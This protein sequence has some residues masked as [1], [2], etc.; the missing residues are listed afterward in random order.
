M[1]PSS[2]SNSGNQPPPPY[3]MRYRNQLRDKLA[4][5]KEYIDERRG[6]DP[7]DTTGWR[8]LLQ[9]FHDLGFI[10]QWPYTGRQTPNLSQ[11]W[12]QRRVANSYLVYYYV[13]EP[14]RTIFLIDLRHGNQKPLKPSTIKKYKSEI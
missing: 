9:I 7:D 13:D 5:I 3:Q 14:N 6:N 12:R 1:L 4:Q 11:A 2:G 10:R 8:V